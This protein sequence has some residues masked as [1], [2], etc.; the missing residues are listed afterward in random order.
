MDTTLPLQT[1]RVTLSWN[2]EYNHEGTTKTYAETVSHV[3]SRYTTDVLTTR[4]DQDIDNCEK[5][6][7]RNE[8]SPK[9]Y[10]S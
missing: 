1:R 3:L 8:Y 10:E 4:A 2:D 6:C 7:K 9:S 5:A